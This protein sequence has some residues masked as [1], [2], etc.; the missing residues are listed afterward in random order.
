MFFDASPAGGGYTQR[1][2]TIDIV[3]NNIIWVLDR[4]P[5]LVQAVFQPGKMK[6]QHKHTA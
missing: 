5:D 3:L 1:R 6:S 2:Q 4:E